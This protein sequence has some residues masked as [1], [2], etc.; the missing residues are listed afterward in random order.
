MA[1]KFS[2]SKTDI[3]LIG[4]T[5]TELTGSKLPSIGMALGLFLH[6]HIELNKTIRESS[7]T[8]IEE[9]KFWQ[10]A[11]IPVQE[12][13][14]CQPKLEKL[15]EQWRLLKKNK[16]RS[17][18]TQKSKEVEFVSKLNNIFDIAHANALNMIKISQ[19][20]EFLLAQL[21][22]GRRGSMLDE[23]KCEEVEATAQLVSSDESD[24]FEQEEQ[25][26]F[27]VKEVD[28][29][30]GNKKRMKVMTPYLAAALDRT[31]VEDCK[32][33][34]VVAEMARSLDYEVVKL[35]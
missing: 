9:I 30:K 2:R 15:F 28:M 16:T 13:I 24:E 1:T 19:D 17:T 29:P 7:T 25:A 4:S 33:V 20:K 14:N 8:T 27:T 34:F 5:I 26:S 21:E 31:K 18:L 23:K 35:L 3:Y 10:K 6:H 22:K 11:R 12:L 32:A